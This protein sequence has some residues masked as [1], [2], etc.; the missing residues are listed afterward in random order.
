MVDACRARVMRS[1]LRLAPSLLLALVAACGGGGDGGGSGGD[2][3]GS[4]AEGGAGG[5][6]LIITEFSYDDSISTL[7]RPV[8]AVP[9]I[10]GLQGHTPHCRVTAGTLPPGETMQDDCT[11]VGTPLAVGSFP[12]TV[13]LTVAG[14]R[15]SVS[16]QA[17]AS[18]VK[19][20]LL[21]VSDGRS[22]APNQTV[23]AGGAPLVSFPVV[24]L[25][26]YVAQPNVTSTYTVESGALPP[27]LTMDPATGTLGG[28]VSGVGTYAFS[29]AVELHY[30][31]ASYK[32]DAQPV[33]LATEVQPL[34]LTYGI[35]C[36]S[37][38]VGD[39]VS[40]AP[41]GNFV[42]FPGAQV[43]YAVQSGLPPGLAIDPATGVLSGV[44]SEQG[45]FTTVVQE[46]VDLPNGTRST[47]ST[48]VGFSVTG[49][50]V[51]YPNLNMVARWDEPFEA[52]PTVV[53]GRQGDVYS[54]Q[55]APY[56]GSTF[57]GN[58]TSTPVPPWLH[59]DPASG[60]IYGVGPPAGS[61]GY[62]YELNAVLTTIRNGHAYVSTQVF[63]VFVLPPLGG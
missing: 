21:A 23:T 55:L 19:P 54:F 59:I 53:N 43:T 29:V 60:R 16:V 10:T 8:H 15:G 6:N 63:Y 48:G 57:N 36:C 42:P 49:P 46:T 13:T 1:A 31:G 2:E 35:A 17:Y 44:P 4:V 40:V 24:N 34:Q 20:R 39:P 22:A 33:V 45:Q 32:T 51:T 18:V 37:V 26:D 62:Q 11:L 56:P 27:G 25:M 3:A 12:I 58:A 5:G 28:V 52:V 47:V 50:R 7:Y 41:T 38:T 14:Y 30:Q 61:I 9:R